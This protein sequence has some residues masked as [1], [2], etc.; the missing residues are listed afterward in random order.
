VGA[1]EN[2]CDEPQTEFK[3]D[4]GIHHIKEDIESLRRSL[5]QLAL[6]QS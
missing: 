5:N 6:L 2:E 1:W 3:P 4:G